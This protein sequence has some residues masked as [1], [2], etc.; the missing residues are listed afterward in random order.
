[1][2]MYPESAMQL[3]TQIHRFSI[4]CTLFAAIGIAIAL[5]PRA[6]A[7]LGEEIMAELPVVIVVEKEPGTGHTRAWR[8]MLPASLAPRRS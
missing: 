6:P 8:Q 7:A 2:S 4:S 5:Q 3:I 1:M